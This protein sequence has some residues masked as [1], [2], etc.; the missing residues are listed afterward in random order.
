[1]SYCTSDL[2]CF[3]YCCVSKRCSSTVRC[4]GISCK[5]HSDCD[6]YLCY[7]NKCTEELTMQILVYFVGPVLIILTIC[8]ILL[9][10]RKCTEG[11]D[12]VTGL[13]PKPQVPQANPEA[14]LSAM[15]QMGMALPQPP[16]PRND[17]SAMNLIPQPNMYPS[18]NPNQPTQNPPM[19]VYGPSQA[20]VPTT[21]VPPQ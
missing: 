21:V 6:S 7:K 3:P 2:Q 12:P 10:L 19:P 14:N 16:A 1:M 8:L 4:E 18:Y 15:P 9:C 11:V 5:T 13:P 20:P 17:F